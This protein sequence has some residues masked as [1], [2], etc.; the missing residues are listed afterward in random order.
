MQVFAK[1]PQ[2]WEGRPLDQEAV[3]RFRRLRA[4]R[5]L[6]PLFTHAAYM[7][8]LGASEGELRRRSIEA[9]A[10]ELGR[11]SVLGADGVVVH[12]GTRA[13]DVA[14]RCAARAGSA[15]A[16]AWERAATACR[17]PTVLIENSAG[18]GRQYGV[19]AGELCDVLDVAAQV[20]DVGICWDTCHAHAAGSDMSSARGWAVVVSE[21]ERRAGRG[22]VRLV[23][24]NDCAAEAG[25]HRDR[26]AWVG[27][28]RIGA[29]GFREMFAAPGLAGADV[30][31]E[32]PGDVPVKDEENVARLKSL[33]GGGAAP[34]A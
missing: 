24:A 29:D 6:A 5:G 23:H 18:A 4:E 9:L 15:I 21:V 1:S 14:G 34:G 31:V 13:D 11:A 3:E 7:I 2:R 16:E 10:D 28:G 8:N 26:H 12:L 27:D 20:A 30:I 17:P 22:C 19:T 33:R 32:M 25:S